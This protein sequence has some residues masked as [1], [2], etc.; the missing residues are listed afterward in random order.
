MGIRTLLKRLERAERAVEDLPI[1]LPECMCFPKRE[2]PDWAQ[3]IESEIAASVKCPLHGERFPPKK[4]WI[5]VSAWYRENRTAH[6]WSHH[7]PQY[8][9]AWFA[10]ICPDLWPAEREVAGDAVCI[11]LKNGTRVGYKSRLEGMSQEDLVAL[12]GDERPAHMPSFDDLHLFTEDEWLELSSPRPI[13][14]A[15]GAGDESTSEVS[16]ENGTGL[17]ETNTIA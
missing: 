8:R 5:Y 14:Q 3:E 6:L 9:K 4:I 15:R 7:T 16:S 2:P 12:C 1:F 10:S 11:R 13:E 17:Q